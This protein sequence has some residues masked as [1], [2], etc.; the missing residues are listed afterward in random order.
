M[1]DL[2]NTIYKYRMKQLLDE[3]GNTLELHPYTDSD[4]V[5]FTTSESAFASATTVKAALD[6]LI[7]KVGNA[8]V[9]HSIELAKGSLA[10][11]LHLIVDGV[12]QNDA[13]IAAIKDTNV[14]SDAAIALTKIAGYSSTS[15]TG[16]NLSL[17]LASIDSKFKA[18]DQSLTTVDSW[19]PFTDGT[20]TIADKTTTLKIAGSGAT[21]VSLASNGTYTI[22]SINNYLSSASFDY[23]GSSQTLTLGRTGLTSI[24]A[25]MLAADGTHSGIVT[26]GDQHFGGTKTFDNSVIISGDLTVNGTLT[27]IGTVDLTVKDFLIEIAKDN[28]TALAHQAGIWIP[29]YNGTDN[30]GLAVDNTGTWRVGKV[31]IGSDGYIDTTSASTQLVPLLARSEE[32]AL[33]D[34]HILVWDATALKAIDAG[35]SIISSAATWVTD[36]AHVP[37]TK[38]II[39]KLGSAVVNSVSMTGDGIVTASNAGT[40][41][42]PAF[43]IAHKKYAAGSGNTVTV[44]AYG[45]V[46]AVSTTNYLLASAESWRTISLG[47][48][49]IIAA[50]DS[51]AFKL[52]QGANIT[53]TGNATDKSI[54]WSLTKANV[55]AALGGTEPV[56]PSNAVTSFKASVSAGPLTVTPTTSSV[57]AVTMTISHNTASNIDA[58]TVYTAMKY[59]AF[60]HAS[61]GAQAFKVAAATTDTMPTDLVIGGIWF[62]RIA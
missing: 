4:I 60:G 40:S 2:T 51:S 59:D 38:A 32:G 8:G 10:G 57:G 47:S 25:T 35:A 31:V 58:A 1:A 61:I 49:V 54:T 29:K 26:F 56:Y 43:S 48:S 5:E 3:A 17:T 27:T 52:V 12:T 41:T 62:Q 42:N 6:L 7:S 21:S 23:S 46:T 39:D 14:A 34:K 44:D 18:I 16:A 30:M 53:M 28:T 24:T 55:I 37:T 20:T 13:V 45:H 19:R 33:T 11:S 9:V 22:S 50:S 15:F 36:D